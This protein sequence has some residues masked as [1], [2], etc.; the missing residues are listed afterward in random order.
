MQGNLGVISEGNGCGTTF[1]IELPLFPVSVATIGGSISLKPSHMLFPSS[2][3]SRFLRH[4]FRCNCFPR[5]STSICDVESPPPIGD[6]G[7]TS[8][9]AENSQCANG[10]D[11]TNDCDRNR[12]PY[13][14]VSI[15]AHDLFSD[16]VSQRNVSLPPSP[17]PAGSVSGYSGGLSINNSFLQ[18]FERN[19]SSRMSGSTG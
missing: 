1:Y 19:Q 9:V 4:V 18:T 6:S 2:L 11:A 16:E 14:Q 12:S 8:G 5:L 3:S 10:S 15:T 7:P 17:L 13:R